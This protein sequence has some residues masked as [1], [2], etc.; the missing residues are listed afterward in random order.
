MIEVMDGDPDLQSGSNGCESSSQEK[1][2]INEGKKAG[3]GGFKR[4]KVKK[5]SEGR[6]VVEGISKMQYP[7]RQRYAAATNQ[8][9]T[10]PSCSV[11]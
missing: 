9:T 2:K 11:V 4:G 7:Q 10:R 5:K 8:R 3:G 1:V 6:I